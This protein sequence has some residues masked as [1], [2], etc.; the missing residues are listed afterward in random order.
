MYLTRKVYVRSEND[1]C[2]VILNGIELDT[3]GLYSLEFKSVYW[4][5]S[6]Q[7]HNWFVKNV[8]GNNDDCDKY[9]VNK[10]ILQELIS[11]CKKDI[12]YL[13]SLEYDLSEEEE[14]WI[15]KEKYTY[16]IYK[17]VNEDKINLPTTSGFFFG[18]TEYNEY[19]KKDLEDTVEMLEKE[20]VKEGNFY[21]SS[22]W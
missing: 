13:E 8:Q 20:I 21:Y 6:N 9:Y 18:S 10:E 7:I 4:R 16:K 2:K 12:A 3:K 14:D 17:D 19:Y 11:I 1:D 22:S 15:T 5:K